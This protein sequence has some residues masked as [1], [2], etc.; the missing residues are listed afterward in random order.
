MPI[1]SLAELAEDAGGTTVNFGKSLA[2]GARNFA[3]GL[4]RDY[5][6][7]A[8]G[9][10][11]Q[12]TVG[13]RF[14]KG[15]WDTVC[16]DSPGGLPPAITPPPTSNCILKWRILYPG[17]G[18]GFEWSNDE[19]VPNSSYTVYHVPRYDLGWNGT[20]NNVYQWELRGDGATITYGP[21]Y[22]GGVVV[23]F[24]SV[25]NTCSVPPIVNP[26]ANRITNNYNITHNDGTTINTP[27]TFGDIKP[28]LDI[29]VD[30]GGVKVALNVD[31][32]K[33]DF[34]NNSVSYGD[35]TNYLG[36]AISEVN[37]TINDNDVAI[38]TKIDTIGDTIVNIE[39]KIDNLPDCSDKDKKPNPDDHDK[40]VYGPKKSDMHD[41]LEGLEW[42]ELHIT[43]FN[44]ASKVQFGG[45]NE[46]VMFVGWIEFR[47]DGNC[48]VREPIH[49]Q[50]NIYK[51]PPHANG[52][53]FTCTYSS[54]GNAIAYI[55]KS[56]S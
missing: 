51:A 25:T 20:N 14:V 35:V 52:F 28:N 49:F 23:S 4:Y 39:D 17:Y 53:G 54:L 33:F 19:P 6:G 44:N 34:S 15:V 10:A 56:I 7:W 48:F 22:P 46:D 2:T 30:V 1:F 41:L 21:Y 38:N 43:N 32:V 26:P 9:Q 27:I 3:C 42:V 8:I 55:K 12:G 40:I 37:N 31:G 18:A 24:D 11:Q 13:G 50:H 5:S 16:A 36:D 47:I 29:T 45:S